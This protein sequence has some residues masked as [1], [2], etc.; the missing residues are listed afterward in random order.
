M[1][2]EGKAP[3]LF[4]PAELAALPLRK[5]SRV[6][7]LNVRGEALL[8]C[9]SS[10]LSP[11]VL[12]RFGSET[13]WT[14]PG[15][16][17]DEGETFAQGAIREVFEETGLVIADPGP[18]IAIREFPMSFGPDWYRAVQHYFA[19]RVDDFALDTSRFT[20]LEQDMVLGHRWWSPGEIETSRDV[21]FPEGLPELVR[22]SLV[23]TK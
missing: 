18:A 17:L 2:A 9:Y 14:T 13:F 20:A 10:R 19:V 16:G 4:S 15:G 6:L 7:L 3:R 22:Q 21:I 5:A 1:A 8:F 11:D 23:Q 12:R